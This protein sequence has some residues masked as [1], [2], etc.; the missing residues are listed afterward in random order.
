MRI[1]FEEIR[2][3]MFKCERGGARRDNTKC[4]SVEWKK[5]LNKASLEVFPQ[6]SD[7]LYKDIMIK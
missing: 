4:L 5:A 2:Y 3:L 6:F 7:G 1:L